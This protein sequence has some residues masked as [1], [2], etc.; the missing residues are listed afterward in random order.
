MCKSFFTV[1]NP[2]HATGLFLY[3]RKTS[4]NMFP[5]G[6]KREQWHEEGERPKIVMKAS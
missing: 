5:E 1:F 6:I 4:E 3:P 2:F